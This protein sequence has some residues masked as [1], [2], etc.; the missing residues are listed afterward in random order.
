MVAICHLWV[1]TQS[2]THMTH[3]STTP[4]PDV[5]PQHMLHKVDHD[6]ALACMGEAW[7]AAWMGVGALSGEF[8]T[9][10]AHH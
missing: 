9:P 2:H 3:T 7:P 10:A 6:T 1:D 5:N 4:S 8:P